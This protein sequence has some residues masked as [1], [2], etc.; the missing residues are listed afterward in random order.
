MASQLPVFD[1]LDGFTFALGHRH[2][3]IERYLRLGVLKPDAVT[4]GGR[5]LF[6]ADAKASSDTG[7]RFERTASGLPPPA[8]PLSDN[9]K[10]FYG[11]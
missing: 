8:M 2:E 9:L 5:P 1:S 4:T 3:T 11:R 7:G 6:L 10:K